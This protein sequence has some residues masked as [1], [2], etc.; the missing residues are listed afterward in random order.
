VNTWRIVEKEAARKCRRKRQK[1]DD[2]G[3]RSGGGGLKGEATLKLSGEICRGKV[4]KE[5]RD[6]EGSNERKQ[7]SLTSDDIEGEE[8]W[9]VAAFPQT[10]HH[11]SD[12]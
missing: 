2:L 7:R 3:N 1:K 6:L 9:E 5:A 10:G 11:E 12:R 4:A 8:G